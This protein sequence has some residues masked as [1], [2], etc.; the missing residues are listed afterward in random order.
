[1][2]EFYAL[3]SE[4][5]PLTVPSDFTGGSCVPAGDTSIDEVCQRNDRQCHSYHWAPSFQLASDIN[6][7]VTTKMLVGILT[8]EVS[9]A[10]VNVSFIPIVG[11]I[12]SSI[13]R[14][15]ITSCIEFFD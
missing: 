3:I 9:F 7:R 12:F 4:A 1:V 2:Y 8:L 11:V 6:S 5:L 10:G 14:H 13:F 15:G